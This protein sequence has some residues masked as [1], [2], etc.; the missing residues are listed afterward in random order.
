[1]LP[2]RIRKFIDIFSALPSIGPRQATRLAFYLLRLGKN[3]ILELS[4]AIQDLVNITTC[5]FCFL[6]FESNNNE[7]LCHIC[8]NNKRKQD[9]IAIVE[10]ETDLVSIEKANKFD[11]RYLILG[12]LDK[13]G[14]LNTEQKLKLKNFKGHIEKKFKKAEEIIIALNPTTV[15]DME[16][17]LL[18]QELSPFAEK[19]TRL[20]RG[21]PTGGEIEFADEDT[22]SGAIENRR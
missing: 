1:M 16:S 9:V 6:P 21:L 12:E 5:K 3:Q 20:G 15:G 8:L 17:A 13:T 18:I 22:L 2:E 4:R 19:I 11:G 14:I 10:K 7:L